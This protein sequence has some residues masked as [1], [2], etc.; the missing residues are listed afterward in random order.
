MKT[1]IEERVMFTISAIALVAILVMVSAPVWAGGGEHHTTGDTNVNVGGDTITME[2]GDLTSGPVNVSTGGNKSLA[3]GNVLGD[4]DIAG[5]LG[6]TQW[7]TPVYGKQKLVVNWVCVAEFYIRYQQPELA[8]MAL[9]NTEILKEFDTE[10]ECEQ[11]HQFLAQAVIQTVDESEDED[12][13][14]HEAL[15]STNMMLQA[16][17]EELKELYERHPTQRPVVVQMFSDDQKARLREVVK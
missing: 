17:I 1:S 7:S 10:E 2:G 14:V 9:C 5:C 15:H 8:A 3:L 16:E 12:E 13:E 6:S 11:A 4:V